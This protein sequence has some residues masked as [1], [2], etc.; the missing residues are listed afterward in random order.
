MFTTDKVS[1]LRLQCKGYL[2]PPIC[3]PK[4]ESTPG[5]CKISASWRQNEELIRELEK[6]WWIKTSQH[7][8]SSTAWPTYSSDFS[9]SAS[10]GKPQTQQCV[11][12]EGCRAVPVRLGL[13][14]P[15]WLS[16]LGGCGL[17][18]RAVQAP[19]LGCVRSASRSLLQ[20]RPSN[21]DLCWWS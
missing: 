17:M 21:V 10:A 2:T 1:G 14:G 19:W 7:R 12:W 9:G 6:Y 4:T 11:G 13:L 18:D 16:W 5:M 15:I 8:C 3:V 20:E